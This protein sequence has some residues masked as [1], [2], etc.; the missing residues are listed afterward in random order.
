[1]REGVVAQD[2]EGEPVCDGAQPSVELGEG[3]FVGACDQGQ[4][5][6]VGEVRQLA[7]VAA[8]DLPPAQWNDAPHR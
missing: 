7:R 8:L 2:S 5:R 3:V 1:L 6:L 4:Q